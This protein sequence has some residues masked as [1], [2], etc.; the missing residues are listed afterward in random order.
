MNVLSMRW[1]ACVLL[2]EAASCR[3]PTQ[4]R[5]RV[6]NDA[7]CPANVRVWTAPTF[8]GIALGSSSSAPTCGGATDDVVLVPGGDSFAL[9]IA[10]RPGG[11][12]GVCAATP[13]PAGCIVQRW[14]LSFRAHTSQ[15]F[16]TTLSPAC[17][18]VTCPAGSTCVNGGCAPSVIDRDC[19]GECVAT[20]D[21]GVDT[22]VADTSVTD[23]T[24]SVVD[25]PPLPVTVRLLNSGSISMAGWL[26]GCVRLPGGGLSE[27]LLAAQ[28]QGPLGSFEVS[29][30][31][32]IPETGDAVSIV[33][34]SQ[35]PPK[36]EGSPFTVNIK[37]PPP[38]GRL[39]VFRT[40]GTIASIAVDT[41][42]DPDTGVTLRGLHAAMGVSGLNL[43]F[44]YR[45][46]ED[47]WPVELA[48]VPFANY[49]KVHRAA[50]AVTL[51]TSRG[52]GFGAN[53]MS[54]K[55]L[56][57]GRTYTI[58]AFAEEAS[59]PTRL[60]VCDDRLDDSTFR[61]VCAY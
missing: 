56:D 28:K 54:F 26:D 24:D 12:S 36:C 32:P 44:G 35:N 9:L 4:F 18:S 59:G 58:F 29:G 23:V 19:S 50:G 61:A 60:R 21:A 33:L 38:G 2:L 22:S 25:A 20:A 13:T 3:T 43:D 30:Q 6:R 1:L 39:I 42:P 48:M 51:A 16:T 46:G 10:T 31:L 37:R 17:L 52:S 34:S 27:P 5:V 55:A 57:P 41:P 11:D 7:A 47:I 8:D 53:T 49:S 15:T 45:A 14:S 40:G